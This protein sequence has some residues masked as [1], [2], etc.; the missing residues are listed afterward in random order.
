MAVLAAIPAASGGRRQGGVGASTMSGR[1]SGQPFPANGSKHRHGYGTENCPRLLPSPSTLLEQVT[2]LR[3]VL[4]Q[5]FGLLAVGD[6]ALADH[7]GFI[8]GAAASGRGVGT[9]L[10]RGHWISS[11]DVQRGIL[12]RREHGVERF[13]LGDGS[14]EAVQQVAGLAVGLGSRRSI[15][16]GDDDFESGTSWP[17]RHVHFVGFLADFGL[18]VARGAEHV[19]GREVC[20]LVG[21]DERSAW[22]PFPAPGGPMKTIRM[23]LVLGFTGT[24]RCGRSTLLQEVDLPAA[25]GHSSL[26]SRLF[27]KAACSCA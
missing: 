23:V 3:V 9:V 2:W 14:G 19:A 6:E 8:V 12:P 10:P 25:P 16:D 18:G 17:A 22:V 24:P 7:V 13:G 1:R 21:L 11:T 27:Q 20:Q 26:G 5:R 4:Q 15:D